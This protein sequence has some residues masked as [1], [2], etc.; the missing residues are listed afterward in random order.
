LVSPRYPRDWVATSSAVGHGRRF[1]PSFM[2]IVAVTPL[3]PWLSRE[4][5]E[6]RDP[7][8]PWKFFPAVFRGSPKGDLKSWLA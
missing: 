4:A 6:Y 7:F 8:A 5:A 3:S 1:W 2:P